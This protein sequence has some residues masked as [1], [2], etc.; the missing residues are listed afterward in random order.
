MLSTQEYAIMFA[1]DCSLA[2]I[3]IKSGGMLIFAYFCSC[4]G[5]GEKIGSDVIDLKS[6]Q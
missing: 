2:Y 5:F 4:L 6:E 1:N 3:G